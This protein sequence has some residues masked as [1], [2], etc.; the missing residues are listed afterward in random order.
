MHAGFLYPST[1]AGASLDRKEVQAL[2][3]CPWDWADNYWRIS[4]ETFAEQMAAIDAP[5]I[6]MLV[7]KNY[8]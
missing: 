6:Y 1:P 8:C 3:A 5:L 2:K 7:N 4:S